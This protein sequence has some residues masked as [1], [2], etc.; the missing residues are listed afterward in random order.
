M[1][2]A[3]TLVSDAVA[4]ATHDQRLSTIW[5]TS[6]G[7]GVVFPLILFALRLRLKEPEE[8]SKESMRHKTPY[9]LVIRYYGF[10]LLVVS[11]VWF[12]YDV[13]LD[14]FLNNLFLYSNIL[15]Q[16]SV[17]Y[18]CLWYLLLVHPRRHLFRFRS[19]HH[20]FWMEHCHQPV[21]YPRNHDWRIC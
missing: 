21:L 13:S 12:L 4:A 19:P 9:L 16:L 1:V 15:T 3:H 20:R 14:S 8:F 11:T 17:L 10:R 6:L 2:A 5:R 18:V 7:I